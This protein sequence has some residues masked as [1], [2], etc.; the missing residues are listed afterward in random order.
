MTDLTQTISKPIYIAIDVAKY[1]HDILIKYP[2]GKQ[3]HL[4]ISNTQEGYQK[5]FFWLRPTFRNCFLFISAF[6]PP[7]SLFLSGIFAHKDYS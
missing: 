3:Q 2:N 5:V 6:L 7:L 4:I 1:K